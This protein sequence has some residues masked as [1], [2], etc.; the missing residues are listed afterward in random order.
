MNSVALIATSATESRSKAKTSSR[1][2]QNWVLSPIQDGLYIIVAPVL[3]LV[4]AIWAF[5]RFGAAE[6]TSFIIVAHIIMTVAHHLPT[7]I[8]V[9]GDVELFKRFKWSFVLGP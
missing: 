9:Y 3:V 8:R 1:P 6:A 7:F 5:S 2:V 4:A